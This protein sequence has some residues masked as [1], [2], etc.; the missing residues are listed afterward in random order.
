MAT[1]PTIRIVPG[2]R[3]GSTNVVING[4][5]YTTTN[6]AQCNRSGMSFPLQSSSLETPAARRPSSGVSS[7][8]LTYPQSLQYLLL[9]AISN[10][11]F[12]I[13]WGPSSI[14]TSRLGWEP[15]T[16]NRSSLTPVGTNT[17]QLHSSF[18]E[19]ATLPRDGTM[20]F[21]LSFPAPIQPFGN[22]YPAWWTSKT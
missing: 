12:L 18:H 22:S 9:G 20:G 14:T 15:L 16:A 8:K 3:A 2:R 10:Q 1:T 11:P 17:M 19:T 13:T 7:G 21:T 5:R 6:L 4:Y